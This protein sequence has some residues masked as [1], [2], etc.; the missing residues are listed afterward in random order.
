MAKIARNTDGVVEF[1]IDQ[2]EEIKDREDLDIDKKTKHTL[3]YLNM[4]MQYCKLN[5][6]NKQ[7]MLKA[8]EIAK[9]RALVLQLGPV[10]VEEIKSDEEEQPKKAAAK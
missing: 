1:C 9:N 10:K 6:A 8:P 2:A 4:A 3:A 5:L 7:L